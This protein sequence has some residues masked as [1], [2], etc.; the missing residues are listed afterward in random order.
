M[1]PLRAA[2][3]ERPAPSCRLL[4]EPHQAL[5]R[6][7]GRVPSTALLWAEKENS[8]HTH[9]HTHT[10]REQPPHTHTLS[11]SSLENKLTKVWPWGSRE[12]IFAVGMG[13]RKK[14]P[15]IFWLLFSHASEACLKRQSGQCSWASQL[16]VAGP[17][18][19][20]P[21]SFVVLTENETK[22]TRLPH[23]PSS[24]PRRHSGLSLP[25]RLFP[26][27]ALWLVKQI[28]VKAKSRTV[29][30]KMGMLTF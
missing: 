15:Y 25:P 24:P 12:L 3:A 6:K 5:T 28:C 19:L 18:T 16:A 21:S 23:S 30:L 14:K 20:L 4:H 8:H 10:E 1:K 9:T 7:M 29:L 17:P 22:L 27:S 2:E 13:Q 26:Y 11:S